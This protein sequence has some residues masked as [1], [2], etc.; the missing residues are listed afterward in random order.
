MIVAVI[1]FFSWTLVY[2]C[3][4]Y[5]MR[6]LTCLM[7]YAKCIISGSSIRKGKIASRAN[8]IVRSVVEFQ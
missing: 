3:I 7:D 5:R 1:L 2:E 6:V 8:F 4:V